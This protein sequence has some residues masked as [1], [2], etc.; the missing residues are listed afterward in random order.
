[1]GVKMTKFDLVQQFMEEIK[2]ENREDI[3]LLDLTPDKKFMDNRLININRALTHYHKLRKYMEIFEQKNVV[4]TSIFPSD[5]YPFLVDFYTGE[6]IELA[7]NKDRLVSRLETHVDKEKYYLSKW[8]D[9]VELS[10]VKVLDIVCDYLAII[11]EKT[12]SYYNDM[13]QEVEI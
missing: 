10:P 3:Y 7:L 11:K 12:E 6:G 2:V 8:D 4:P 5:S 9:I 1:M 13:M